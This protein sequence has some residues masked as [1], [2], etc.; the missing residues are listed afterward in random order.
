MNVIIESDST[1]VYEDSDEDHSVSVDTTYS[2][3]SFKTN[4]PAK[5]SMGAAFQMFDNLTL[6]AEWQQGLNEEFGNSTTPRVGVGAE[7]FPLKWLPLRT[8]MAVG[9]RVGFLYGM[10]IGLNFSHFRFDYSYA[11]NKAMWPSSSNGL[12]TALSMKLLF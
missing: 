11:M 6:T 4:L 3:G 9:G 8:G 12:F 7:Y 1:N 2:A 10:G 5:M